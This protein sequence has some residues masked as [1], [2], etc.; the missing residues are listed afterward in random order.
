MP[1]TK[2]QFTEMRE[3]SRKLIMESALKLFSANGFHA[4]SINKIAADAGIATG[5]AYNYFTSKE[6][7]LDKIV[8]EALADF[9]D[10]V[11]TFVQEG[12]D[13]DNF[14][15]LIDTVFDMVKDKKDSWR[16]IISVM[17]QPDVAE[18]G[19]KNLSQFGDKLAQLYENYF[20]KKGEKAVKKKVRLL[21]E[22]IHAAI[23]SFI[24]S[25]DEE[26]LELIK[27]ELII[28]ILN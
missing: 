22:L 4:T 7:L 9:P 13:G 14:S 1:R 24:I 17:L 15:K 16:L 18:I 6:D 19:R 27:N 26:V 12:L 2:E 8:K 10:A 28:K 3:K 11:N 20:R 5:L 25:E 21:I 23:L